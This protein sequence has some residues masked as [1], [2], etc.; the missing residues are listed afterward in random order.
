VTDLKLHQGLNGVDEQRTLESPKRVSGNVKYMIAKR[1]KPTMPEDMSKLE[2]S[3]P[4]KEI[5]CLNLEQKTLRCHI[6]LGLL[7]EWLESPPPFTWVQPQ[8]QTSF[9][10]SQYL[11]HGYDD[12][13]QSAKSPFI[14]PTRNCSLFHIYPSS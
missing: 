12:K 4:I 6:L 9:K 2:L 11:Q 8:F 3:G 5:V 14:L 7:L 13:T 10:I 1:K